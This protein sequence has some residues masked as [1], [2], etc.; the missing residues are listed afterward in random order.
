[1]RGDM[2]NLPNA[3]SQKPLGGIHNCISHNTYCCW[4]CHTFGPQWA[5]CDSALALLT[6]QTRVFCDSLV[7]K[8]ALPSF[9]RRS[10]GKRQAALLN[11]TLGLPAGGTGISCQLRAIRNHVELAMSRACLQPDS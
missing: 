8:I 7:L 2:S 4:Y 9:A 3:T 10:P 1:M 11:I 5:T 6:S